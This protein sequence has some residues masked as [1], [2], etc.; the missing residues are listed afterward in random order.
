M[1]RRMLLRSLLLHR[2]FVMS[3]VLFGNNNNR[4]MLAVERV[5]ENT[6]LGPVVIFEIDGVGRFQKCSVMFVH[7]EKD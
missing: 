4:S 1:T 5:V 3:F 7:G 6:P 2:F